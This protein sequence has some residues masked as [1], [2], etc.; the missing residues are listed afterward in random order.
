MS[1]PNTVTGRVCIEAVLE[2]EKTATKEECTYRYGECFPR[3][4]SHRVTEENDVRLCM[5]IVNY[6]K[7]EAIAVLRDILN[8]KVREQGKKL[9]HEEIRI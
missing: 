1:G 3:T 5:D 6:N 8:G 9:V 7:D 2:S 4:E